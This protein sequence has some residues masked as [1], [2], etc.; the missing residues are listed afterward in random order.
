[1]KKITTLLLAILMV[2]PALAHNL[3]ANYY[4]YFSLPDGWAADKK[5][6]IMIG[7]DSYSICYEMT[8][9]EGTNLYY[10]KS[11]KWDGY[12]QYAVISAE[13]VWP[14]E[15]NGE[16]SKPENRKY[17]G[18]NKTSGVGTT[19]LQKYSLLGGDAKPVNNSSSSDSFL[20]YTQTVQVV[21]D[22][23]IKMSS[24]SVTNGTATATSGTTS[25]VAAYTATV[26][27]TATVADGYQFVGWYEG[28]KKK[29]DNLI[30]T[31]TAEKA[32]K[33][34]IAKF[35]EVTP[36]TPV[37]S[38][39][40]ASA[41]EVM[42]GETITFNCAVERGDVANIVY[43]IDGEAIVG[44]TW[45]PESCG[46]YTAT[47]TYDGAS[48]IEL[49]SK[50]TVKEELVFNVTVPEGTPACYIA[51]DMN[52]WSFTAMTEVDDTHYTWSYETTTKNFEY[53][54]TCA[55]SWDN[56]ELD[57]EGN[58]ITNRT[59]N[60]NDVVVMFKGYG[61]CTE[62]ITYN[63]SYLLN[64][65]A[66][67][68]KADGAKFG[69]W[70]YNKNMAENNAILV[71]GYPL[72]VKVDGKEVTNDDVILFYLDENHVIDNLGEA[73]NFTHVVFLRLNPQYT[74]TDYA[75]WPGDENVWDKV[76]TYCPGADKYFQLTD[77]KA[78][79]WRDL[80]PTAT[81]LDR[82]EVAN[83]IGYAYGVVSAEGAI[84]V[85]NVNGA[86]VARGNNNVDLRGL[87]RGVY[88]IR[89][90]N[91]VRKVVR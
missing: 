19:E 87:G 49:D 85:Y 64:I 14:G 70:F 86:V 23:T 22:G 71:E 76:D 66:V 58:D 88:I 11:V 67:D 74:F 72:V 52:G 38:N 12:T 42:A 83:G 46:E 31:Y 39:F 18:L 45:T 9:L 44:N 41:V 68:W 1:M 91:Q 16:S 59:Y 65:E 89:T 81:A 32:T 50:I 15:G 69:A 78:G 57:A 10:W 54:Y 43:K 28:E 84:E 75:T 13:V 33:N 5:T 82:V 6:Q 2:L 53:K 55:E 24:V 90:G 48:P 30:Y 40:T 20:N 21:G 47:A 60:A 27:C 7:H 3:P 51:G 56:V 29:S 62:N 61:K 73:I 36:E 25:V 26:T 63:N 79:E 37:L 17:Y 77:W 34:L 4:V 80:D 35:E 8:K